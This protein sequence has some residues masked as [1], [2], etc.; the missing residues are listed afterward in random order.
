VR[1]SY[2]FDVAPVPVPGV[3]IGPSKTTIRPTL[4]VT[5]RGQISP[6]PETVRMTV[7]CPKPIVAPGTV[8]PFSLVLNL[9]AVDSDLSNTLVF[10]LEKYCRIRECLEDM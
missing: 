1:Y 2:A 9:S 3:G 8:Y 6:R 5:Q 7:P 10:R 4:N